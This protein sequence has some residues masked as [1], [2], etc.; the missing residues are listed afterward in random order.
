MEARKIKVKWSTNEE[1]ER[2]QTGE[3]DGKNESHQ[4]VVS[5]KERKKREHR[6]WQPLFTRDFR[7][8]KCRH[9]SN[10]IKDSVL[11]YVP[12]LLCWQ[13]LPVS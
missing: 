1:S 4:T 8:V 11:S 3:M 5:E 2:R 12:L 7:P 9:L 6:T 10:T 13:A